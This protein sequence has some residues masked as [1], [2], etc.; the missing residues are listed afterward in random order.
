[1]TKAE[2]DKLLDEQP[3]HP[4]VTWERILAHAFNNELPPLPPK[5]AGGGK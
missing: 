4:L 1:M 5:P 3:Y 2:L